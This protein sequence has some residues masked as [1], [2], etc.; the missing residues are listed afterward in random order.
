MAVRL[1]NYDSRGQKYEAI[2]QD[3]GTMAPEYTQ[4]YT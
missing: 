3:D 2:S 1:G 4:E